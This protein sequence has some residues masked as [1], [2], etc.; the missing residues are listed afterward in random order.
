[1]PLQIKALGY[2]LKPGERFIDSN[3][4]VDAGE[5][6]SGDDTSNEASHTYK[7]T[8]VLDKIEEISEGRDG[9]ALP[10]VETLDITS[11]Q[12]CSDELNR[13]EI[14]KLEEHFKLIASDC[15]RR[16]LQ[17]LAKMG[18]GF[19]RPSDFYADMV[20]TDVQMARVVKKLANRSNVIQEKKRRQSM[21]VKKVFDK[22]VKQRQMKNKFVK[23]VDN[24]IRNGKNNGA[25][26]KQIDR[27]I[28]NHSKDERKSKSAGASTKSQ[29]RLRQRN[30]KTV[31]KPSKKQ[32]LR[33]PKVRRSSG[34]K[35]AKGVKG[36]KGKKGSGRGKTRGRK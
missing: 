5:D 21:K 22:Q 20:K 17:R 14:L 30:E 23:D 6:S 3:D 36:N 1:M 13:N 31:N 27:L 18:I 9:K 7:E 26:E 15:A 4:L 28:D 10:W 11:E 19:N 25:I 29:K 35:A 33:N 32:M 16:G 8:D 34:G 24:L 12:K 2:V